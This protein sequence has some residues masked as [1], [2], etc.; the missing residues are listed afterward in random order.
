MTAGVQAWSAPRKLFTGSSRT[1]AH[2]LSSSSNHRS[3]QNNRSIY[4][5]KE[6]KIF[7]FVTF[8]IKLLIQISKIFKLLVELNKLIALVVDAW[9]CPICYQIETNKK[10]TYENLLK[11]YQTELTLKCFQKEFTFHFGW[12]IQ[13]SDKSAFIISLTPLRLISS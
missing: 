13:K 12:I 10:A 11:S 6:T 4:L 3:K 8:C 5:L 9:S 1:Y 7:V 2:T